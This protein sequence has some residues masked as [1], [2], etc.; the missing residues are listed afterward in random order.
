M[1]MITGYGN[2]RKLKTG[3][4]KR[5]QNNCHNFVKLKKKKKEKK[6]HKSLV[7]EMK[8]PSLLVSWDVEK[9]EKKYYE[10]F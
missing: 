10:H 6:T 7:S 8:R 5:N 1:K 3:F 2:S 4:L 9:L